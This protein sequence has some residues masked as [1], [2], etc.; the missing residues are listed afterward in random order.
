MAYSREGTGG[1]KEAVIQRSI[2]E[3]SG[4]TLFTLYPKL[5]GQTRDKVCPFVVYAGAT[6]NTEFGELKLNTDPADFTSFRRVFSGED[7]VVVV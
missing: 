3:V 2:A 4:A 6:N 7:A 1:F 5:E